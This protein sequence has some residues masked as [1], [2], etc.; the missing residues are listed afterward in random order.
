MDAKEYFRLMRP[1]ERLRLPLTTKGK[2]ENPVQPAR[3]GG[4]VKNWIAII[5]GDDGELGRDFLERTYPTVDSAPLYDSD[6][7]H[8]GDAIEMA[9][10]VIGNGPKGGKTTHKETRWYGMVVE[11]AT[12]GVVLDRYEDQ[13]GALV[14]SARGVAVVEGRAPKAKA[15]AGERAEIE[16]R[17]T[18]DEARL[19]EIK[20]IEYV[21]SLFSMAENL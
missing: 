15:L 5:Y 2:F 3:D 10:D 17:M 13:I 1:V 16:A 4:K 18:A 14:R 12:N 9:C 19:R 8:S 6:A 7:L 20:A 11:V 21:E